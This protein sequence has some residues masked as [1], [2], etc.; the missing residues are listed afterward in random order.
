M[1]LADIITAFEAR[2]PLALQEPWDQCGLNLGS[3]SQE[4]KSVLFSYDVCK[5][6]VKAAV[7]KKCQLIVSHHPFRLRGDVKINL[8]DY[9]GEIIATCIRNNIALYASHTNHDASADSLNF[10]YLRKL[11]LNQI[12]PLTTAPIKLLKLIV[13]VPTTHTKRV[14][15]ALFKAGAGVIGNYSEC[16][17][18]TRGTG[19]FFGNEFTNPA[20]GKKLRREEVDEERLEV[21]LK[22]HDRAKIIGALYQAHPYEEV[23]YD[24]Y[25]LENKMESLGLGAW[26][27]ASKALSKAE[28][29]T[30]LKRLFKTKNIRFVQGS[31][32][33]FKRIGIGTGSGASLLNEAFKKK[34]DLFITGDVRYHQAIEAKRRDLA[35]ADVGHFYSENQAP[36]VLRNVF[37]ELFGDRL[38]LSVYKGLKDAFVFC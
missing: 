7:R 22:D 19:S 23:A 16:S 29:I 36:E 28:V 21:I 20:I 4:V 17:F 11:K 12:Q 15:N 5:E 3:P 35:I 31:Q 8:D 6:V 37:R 27:V 24:L 33:K 30:R 32:K 14:M 25:A 18:R 1:K 34:L 38:K 2:I 26:G 13:F 9:E 10:F